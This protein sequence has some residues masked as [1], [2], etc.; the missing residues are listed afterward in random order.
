ML[1]NIFALVLLLS[2]SVG[3]SADSDKPNKGSK[4][5][6][7]QEPIMGRDA[8]TEERTEFKVFESVQNTGGTN[9]AKDFAKMTFYVAPF[10]R[11]VP[12]H[13]SPY[14]D[15]E[16]KQDG[17]VKY[18]FYIE[19]VADR[20]REQALQRIN[21]QYGHEFKLNQIQPMTHGMVEIV[22]NNLPERLNNVI[23]PV[24]L[25]N[26]NVTTTRFKLNKKHP[27]SLFVPIVVNDTFKSILDSPDGVQFTFKVYFN[28]MNLQQKILKWKLEDVKEVYRD[29]GLEGSGAEYFDAQQ[30]QDFF[31]QVAKRASVFDYEDPGIADKIDSK[32]REIFDRLTQL[33][34][35]ITISSLQEA[36]KL[37]NKLLEGIGLSMDDFKPITL[38]WE[39]SE[40]LENAT[41]YK[42][43]N[44]VIKEAYNRNKNAVESMNSNYKRKKHDFN[45]SMSVSSDTSVE[46]DLGI[47]SVKNNTKVGFNTDYGY[48]SDK[49]NQDSKKTE[50]I[51]DK[52][53]NGYFANDDEFHEYKSKKRSAKGQEVRIVG[54]GLNVVDKLTLKNE[55]KTMVDSVSVRPMTEISNFTAN[56]SISSSSVDEVPTTLEKLKK[57]ALLTDAV[58]VS[59]DGNVGIGTTNPKSKLHIHHDNNNTGLLLTRDVGNPYLRFK[60]GSKVAEIQFIVQGDDYS[61]NPMLFIQNGDAHSLGRVSI[62]ADVG[63]GTTDPKA[64]LEVAGN[65][66]A[67]SFEGQVKQLNSYGVG[68]ENDTA[69]KAFLEESNCK[70]GTITA[71]KYPRSEPNTNIQQAAI[72]VCVDG[73]KGK[74]W[75]C[76]N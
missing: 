76:F 38:V 16:L 21:D 12:K 41:D 34:Q 2:A 1:K 50:Q 46:A 23:K 74:G 15:R 17:V 61:S 37:E 29:M 72:C 58:S 7:A 10:L 63:I 26:A 47:A 8:Y 69:D 62:N 30:I 20:I 25:P 11:L 67:H 45:A 14:D 32:G 36:Q 60:D 19:A 44:K 49:I 71:A 54:R 33:E 55:L 52:I 22:P 65:I 4:V 24:V 6:L 3:F 35:D 70:A 68:I 31:T 59:E 39:V 73:E 5:V 43:A 27:F 75:Y 56:S 13:G 51:E 9:G 64:K 48:S 18:T 40:Q 42:T 66:K 57:A 28:A 53:N